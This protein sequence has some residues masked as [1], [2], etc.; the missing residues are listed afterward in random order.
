MTKPVWISQSKDWSFHT[1]STYQTTYFP[2]KGFM[3]VVVLLLGPSGAAQR[4]LTLLNWAVNTHTY[5]LKQWDKV[6]LE[7]WFSVI[8]ALVCTHDLSDQVWVEQG[9]GGIPESCGSEMRTDAATH[10]T[11]NKSVDICCCL[12]TKWSILFVWNNKHDQISTEC[13][14]ES[15]KCWVF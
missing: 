12:W 11:V 7:Q 3:A 4:G 15:Q 1:W 6:T 8:L 14:Y 5:T 10:Q 2:I 13:F 9:E